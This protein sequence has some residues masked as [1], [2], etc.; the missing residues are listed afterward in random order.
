MGNEITSNKKVTILDLK[1]YLGLEIITEGNLELQIKVPSIYQIGYELVGFFEVDEE[2]NN[3][4]HIYGRKESRFLAKF[5]E[6]E[7]KK[8]LMSTLNIIFQL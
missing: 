1:E 8:Y 3:Y 7:R 6:E 4:I 2:L 5:S